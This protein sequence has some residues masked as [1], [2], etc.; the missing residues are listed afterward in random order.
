VGKY[1]AVAVILLAG[2]A[3]LFPQAMSWAYIAGVI[4]YELWLARRMRGTGTSPVAVDEPPYRFTMEEA[5]LVGHYR[6]Y[7]TYPVIAKEAASVLSAIGLSAIFLALWLT[8]TQALVQAALAGVNL[9]LVSRL[10][11]RAAPLLALR[12]AASKGD[13][14]ALRALELHDPLWA[15]IRAANAEAAT[16]A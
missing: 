8:Y 7:F 15:K 4:G 2:F 9:F 12:I 5:Q 1:G 13:R 14:A 11:K 6:F 10:T 16:A 3:A